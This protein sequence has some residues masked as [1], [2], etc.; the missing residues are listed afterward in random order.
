M[1][2]KAKFRMTWQEWVICYIGALGFGGLAWWA[3]GNQWAGFGVIVIFTAA[4]TL[5]MKSRKASAEPAVVSTEG[6]TRQQ[7]RAHERKNK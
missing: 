3:T 7:R 4:Y 1:I 2:T 5:I 6:M